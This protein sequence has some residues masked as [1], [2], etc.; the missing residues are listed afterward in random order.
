[1][2]KAW[3]LFSRQTHL[4][5]LHSSALKATPIERTLPA[6]E[7]LDKGNSRLLAIIDKRIAERN[8]LAIQV[9]T[10]GCLA[11]KQ[12]LSIAD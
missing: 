11:Q 3:A 12:R 7:A 6:L 8:S 1:M 9:R 5:K 10:A 2:L 4:R